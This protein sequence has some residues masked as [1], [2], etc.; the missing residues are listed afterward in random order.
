MLLRYHP[1]F[2]VT[3]QIKDV[4]HDLKTLAN[5]RNIFVAF[6]TFSYSAYMMNPRVAQVCSMANA[7]HINP[8]SDKLGQTKLTVFSA[9]GQS[10]IAEKQVKERVEWMTKTTDISI[11][12]CSDPIVKASGN[13]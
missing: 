2:F 6:S 1:H 3:V 10:S 8:E 4:L 12:N 7:T 13:C 9:P 5:A 11:V